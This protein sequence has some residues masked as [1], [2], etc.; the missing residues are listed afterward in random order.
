MKLL[1]LIDDVTGW[2]LRAVAGLCLAT[3]FII[4]FANVLSRYFQIWSMAWFDEIVQALF[5]WMVF[6][7]AAALWREKEHFSV[8]W[9]SAILGQGR[10]GTILHMAVGLVSMAFLALMTWK[11]LDL[12]LR[13]RAVTPILNLPVAFLYA[14]IP[15][16]GAVMTAYSLAEL[17]RDERAF[18]K[19]S[20]A[21]TQ[22]T[23]A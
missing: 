10:K 18:F 8:D 16:A 9:L 13:S 14:S 22:E 23:E 6:I 21:T 20:N 7:G 1:R 5:A 15:I 11:G 3:L 4:L 17:C 12:T 19:P 2:L